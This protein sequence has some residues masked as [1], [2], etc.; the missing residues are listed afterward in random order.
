MSSDRFARHFPDG[1]RPDDPLLQ[2]LRGADTSAS[3][4]PTVQSPIDRLSRPPAAAPGGDTV[5]TASTPPPADPSVEGLLS[6]WHALRQQGQNPAAEE[7]CAGSP[8]LL[9]ELRRG[10]AALASMEGFLGAG[11]TPSLTTPLPDA[12]PPDAAA[13][14]RPPQGP[15]ELGRL[16]GYRVLKLL[17]QGGRGAVFLAEDVQLERQIALKVM[18]PD[19]AAKPEARQR[20]V[21]EAKATAK[22]KDDHVVAIYQVGEDGGVP[23]LAM[24]YLRGESL[25]SWLRRGKQLSAAQVLRA[26]GTS[27]A[28]WRRRT[29]RGWSTATSSRRTCGWRRRRGGSRSS[30]SAWPAAARRRCS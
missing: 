14:L 19:L 17:G 28:A 2:T 18:R 9:G 6:R 3:L 10:L 11:G 1:L 25:E 7:L 5:A 30:T 13:G 24:E 22:L 21:R 26:R 4:H 23:F 27:R 15:G 12:R 8:E 20:F 16:G 29:P